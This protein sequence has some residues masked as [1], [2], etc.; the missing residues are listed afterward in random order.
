MLFIE[1]GVDAF[2]ALLYPEQN[3]VNDYYIQNQLNN[4]SQT[5]TNT[6]R[7]FIEGAKAVYEQLNS[8]ESMRIAKAALRAARG[9]FTPDTIMYLDTV[10]SMQTAK[11]VMQRWIMAQPDIRELY[12]EQRCAGYPD[13]YH[14][15]FGN[16][17]YDDHYD[18]RR[19]MDSIVVEDDDGWYVRYYPDDIIE[20]D[21]E[22]TFIEKVEI[23]S[24]W[25]I[26][27]MFVE[28]GKSDPTDPY[29]GSL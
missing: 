29:G 12:L 13:T 20:G 15:V 25:D 28:A 7:Q 11:S 5:L 3:P 26:V 18:Y 4:F 9:L 16:V 10:E 6:G 21:R 23:L 1:G 19:V 17:N 22:L 27:K 24:T 2:D 14:N 8:A